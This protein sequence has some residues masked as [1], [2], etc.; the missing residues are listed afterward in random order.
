MKDLIWLRF[1]TSFL[2]FGFSL[3]EPTQF[4]GRMHRMIKLGLSIGDDDE[5]LGGADDLPPLWEVEGAADEAAKLNEVD[6][7]ACQGWSLRK[8]WLWPGAIACT[9]SFV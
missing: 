1:D 2:T 9:S 7:A 3:E 6:L 4:A 5:G 8:V